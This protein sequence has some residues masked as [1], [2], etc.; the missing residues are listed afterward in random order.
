MPNALPPGST[1]PADQIVAK[2]QSGAMTL[3]DTRSPEEIAMT[4]KAKGALELT[5]DRFAREVDPHSPDHRADL[6]TDRP[7][8]LYCASGARSGMAA[9]AML[10]MG[11][12][13]V[14]N[15]G[16]LYDWQQAGGEM[17]G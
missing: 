4:G 9:Q 1:M 2:V 12:A 10:Q 13:E 14:H 15:L 7:V 3:I 6:P 17:E 5:L 16:G 8:A 11:Y